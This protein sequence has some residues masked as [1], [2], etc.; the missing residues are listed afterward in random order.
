[1]AAPT[2][3]PFATMSIPVAMQATVVPKPPQ[4]CTVPFA[5]QGQSLTGSVRSGTPTRSQ[6][7]AVVA[8]TQVHPLHPP[9]RI[10][11]MTSRQ[12]SC[13]SLP[14]LRAAQMA[15]G[16][17][18][19]ASVATTSAGGTVY[20][21]APLMATVQTASF[22]PPVEPA[23][24]AGTQCSYRNPVSTSEAVPHQQ[25]RVGAASWS[26]TEDVLQGE[27]ESLRRTVQVQEDRITHLRKELQA[28]RENESNAASAAS[29]AE[30]DRLEIARLRK[31]L[32]L[33]RSAREQ[34]EAAAA[35]Q[36]VAAEMAMQAAQ[37][38]MP[39]GYERVSSTPPMPQPRSGSVPRN[40]SS[41]F[42][43][44]RGQ[45]EQS[46]VGLQPATDRPMRPA[47]ARHGSSSITS[48]VGGAVP[49][50]ARRGQ[51][52]TTSTSARRGASPPRKPKDEIDARLQ[53]FLQ[54]SERELMFQRLNRGWYSVRRPDEPRSEAVNVEISIVNG[55][56]MAKLEPSTHDPGWN[57][58]K[59]GAIERF[60]AAYSSVT[61][62]H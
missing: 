11:S 14:G 48:P 8:G 12:G 37:A 2:P 41:G 29:N 52:N 6:V 35:E 40:A 28:S 56:L 17:I 7:Y 9:Q 3:A 60:V 5:V 43:D 51:V 27:I 58:G 20:S 23:A 38:T 45:D 42:Q 44:R 55:K 32:G 15:A 34:A 49:S 18:P 59:L 30:A 21:Q 16:M 13:S 53:E 57:N 22:V 39:R 33:E 50:S 1:M 24:E 26:H 31:E 47:S 19:Q 46:Q 62:R 10:T 54:M 36:Q 61:E 4:P 25:V